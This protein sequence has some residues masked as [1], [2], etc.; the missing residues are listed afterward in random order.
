MSQTYTRIL[1]AIVHAILLTQKGLSAP[2]PPVPG[3]E[4]FKIRLELWCFH[5]AFCVTT[6]RITQHLQPVIRNPLLNHMLL[7]CLYHT[8]GHLVSQINL[9]LS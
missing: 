6:K 4:S 8:R 1:R 7:C 9:D 5:D 2:P 3:P